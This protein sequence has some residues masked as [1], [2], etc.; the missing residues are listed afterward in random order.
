MR[1][2][3]GRCKG[4][5]LYS[6]QSKLI[7][8]TSD[9]IKEFIF[10]YIGE[11]VREAVI[12]DLYSGT[13]NLAIEALSRGAQFAVLIDNS[14]EA[15]QLI[16]RNLKSTNLLAQS[17]IVKQDVLRYLKKAIQQKSQYNLIFADPP[18][19]NNDYHNVI[20]YVGSD[21]L[22]QN[23]GFFILEYSSKK[24]IAVSAACLTLQ[25]TKV[26]GDTSIT[27]YKKKEN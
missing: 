2:I 11:L 18:Y 22:L 3:S 20:E 1:V 19:F 12:L 14:T 7:R 5:V 24:N 8:P 17:K 21:N 15:I 25:K 23:G 27:F 16:Y 4:R 13:G 10:D 9:K 6:P 26:F